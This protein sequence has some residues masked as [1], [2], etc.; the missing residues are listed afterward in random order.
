MPE[1]LPEFVALVRSMRE[2]QRDYFKTRSGEALSRSK[3][4]E[5]KVDAA[6]RAAAEAEKPNLF[7]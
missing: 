1:D 5:R 3:E 7:S 6:L 2:A 4:L